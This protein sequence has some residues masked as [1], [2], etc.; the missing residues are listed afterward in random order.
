M[1]ARRF[2]GPSCPPTI[3]CSGPELSHG[4]AERATAWPYGELPG[5]L[6][7]VGSLARRKRDEARG[8]AGSV[9]SA[10][11]A[12]I[13]ELAAY[14]GACSGRRTLYTGLRFSLEA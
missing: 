5:V 7:L 3:C 12:G 14:N 13:P 11:V 10:A 4:D 8:C 6:L 9:R 1:N 2:R